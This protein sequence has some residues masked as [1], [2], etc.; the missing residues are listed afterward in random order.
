[1]RLKAAGEPVTPNFNRWLNHSPVLPLTLAS[2]CRGGCSPAQHGSRSKYVAGCRCDPC[3]DAEAL[4]SR[5]RKRPRCRHGH[6]YTKA[7]TY[8]DRKGKRRC[9][10]CMR[11][12]WREANAARP[13]CR[14]YSLKCPKCRDA[15][16]APSTKKVART[17]TT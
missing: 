4:Y 10:I 13:E 11:A 2:E 7:N 17:S 5:N 8:T 6:R 15:G 1:M 9:R 12:Q 3:R 14:C 16:R